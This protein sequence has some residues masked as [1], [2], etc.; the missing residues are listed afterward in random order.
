[1]DKP[2]PG[3]DEAVKMGCTCP[4]SDNAYGIGAWGTSGPDAVFWRN[5]NC[6]LHGYDSNTMKPAQF[7][8]AQFGP[9]VDSSPP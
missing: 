8:H 6:P 5:I 7:G 3:S 1:M 9:A 4:C 2:N